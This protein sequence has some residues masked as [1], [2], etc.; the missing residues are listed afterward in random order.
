MAGK[1]L[2]I[3]GDN[4]LRHSLRSRLQADGFSVVTV[5]DGEA[6]LRAVSLESPDAIILELKPP[7]ANGV[8]DYRLLRSDPDVG[9]VPILVLIGEGGDIDQITSLGF[10][11]DDFMIEPY[12]ERE[13][14]A[15]LKT[16]LR[17]TALSPRPRMIRAG[18]IEID[19]DRYV[20]K[21]SG[22]QVQ[23]TS[24]EFDL[25]RALLE[26]KGRVL[27]RQVLLEKV[28]GYGESADFETRTIDVHIRRIRGKLGAEGRRIL[29][30]RNVGYRFEMSLA[31]L[32]K[33]SSRAVST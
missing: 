26:A 27:R 31:L 8:S 12:N 22:E 2:V 29:T 24:K 4:A 10:D 15:R 6:A 19:L 3:E 16:L 9:G 20:V 13:L 30:V 28:W 11:A 1:I 32:E 33:A 7:V 18:A 17:R 23:L 21:V 14:F 5:T 25:L